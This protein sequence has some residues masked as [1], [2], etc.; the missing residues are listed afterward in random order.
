MLSN[1]RRKASFSV[2]HSWLCWNTSLHLWKFKTWM[3]ICR[4]LT[5]YTRIP[6]KD[7]ILTSPGTSGSGWKRERAELFPNHSENQKIRGSENR[8]TCEGV[9][10]I[11]PKRDWEAINT[12]NGDSWPSRPLCSRDFTLYIRVRKAFL[13][14]LTDPSGNNER[15][16]Y[17]GSQSTLK[18][19]SKSASHCPLWA[20]ST[21]PLLLIMSAQSRC[22]RHLAGPLK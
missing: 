15:Y 20:H 13:G 8:S 5:V 11:P 16:Q 4:G 19:N 12:V 21:S 17:E 6:E 22:T 1:R 14:N 18:W 10:I 2:S 3:F 7:H 9:G